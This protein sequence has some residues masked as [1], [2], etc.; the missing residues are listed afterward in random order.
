MSGSSLAPQIPTIVLD[1]C[2]SNDLDDRSCVTSTSSSPDTSLASTPSAEVEVIGKYDLA[3][4]DDIEEFMRAHVAQLFNPAVEISI[5]DKQTFG[6]LCQDAHGREMFAKFVNMQ[7]CNS[8]KVNESTFYKLTHSFAL[9][10]FECYDADDFIPCKTLMNMAFTYYHIPEI[11]SMQFSQETHYPVELKSPDS[12]FVANYA[13]EL[14]SASDNDTKEKS[15]NKKQKKNKNLS[16]KGTNGSSSIWKAANLWVNKEIKGIKDSLSAMEEKSTINQNNNTE[17]EK[18]DE[19]VYLYDALKNQVI[20]KSLRFWNAAF[21]DA[22][23]V[24]RQQHCSQIGWNDLTPEERENANEV[25][26]NVTF[27]QLGTFINNMKYLGIGQKTC[28]EFL[29]KQCIIGNLSKELYQTLKC[30]IETPLPSSS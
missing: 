1:Y 20:W 11:S 9:V 29:R 15:E 19:K 14:S 18:D 27:G 3:F 8:Q 23:N 26:R 21:F 7:R 16:K 2:S 24:E 25:I 28:L 12:E 22:V 30:Q 13:H 5:A 4:E 17:K 6:R 10:L